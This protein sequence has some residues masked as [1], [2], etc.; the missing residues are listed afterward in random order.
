MDE[1]LSAHSCLADAE[2]LSVTMTVMLYLP[3]GRFATVTLEAFDGAIDVPFLNHVALY[4]SPESTSMKVALNFC[5]PDCEAM[6]GSEAGDTDVIAGASLT[7]RTVT[8]TSFDAVS[9]TPSVARKK[10]L[11]W[12]VKLAEP[13]M[14]AIFVVWLMRTMT[15]LFPVARQVICSS[16]L[17]ASVMKS[18]R[19]SVALWPSSGMVTLGM[20]ALKTGGMKSPIDTTVEFCL[21]FPEASAA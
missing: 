17:L 5:E 19:L 21:A 12:P 6:V 7:L 1:T 14:F 3:V 9:K 18:L 4:L 2:A 8:T 16:V 20:A 10:M 15:L 11:S 13:L